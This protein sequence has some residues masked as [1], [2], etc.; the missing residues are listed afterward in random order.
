VYPS[1]LHAVGPIPAKRYAARTACSGP[2]ESVS[3]RSSGSVQV[4]GRFWFAADVVGGVIVS[5]STHAGR[6]ASAA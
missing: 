1:V 5:T 6:L 3:A 4:S 2:D